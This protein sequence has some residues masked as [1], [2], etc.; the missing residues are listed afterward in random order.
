[1]TSLVKRTAAT[2]SRV[3]DITKSSAKWQFPLVYHNDIV[4]I[5]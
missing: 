1:M 4:N 5:S 2:F 3:K